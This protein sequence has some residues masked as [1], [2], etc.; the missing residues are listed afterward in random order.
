MK[1]LM[2]LCVFVLLLLPVAASAAATI[3]TSTDCIERAFDLDG[4]TVLYTGEVIGDVMP[5]GEYAWVNVSDGANAIGVW[6]SKDML[7][8]I[9]VAGRYGSVGDSLQITGVFHRACQEHGGDMD[10]HAQQM[11]VMEVGHAASRP[12]SGMMILAA[13]LFAGLDVVLLIVYWR[14]RSPRG[15]R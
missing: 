2:I 11:I 10:I 3:I 12:A 9:S 13:M 14:R 6:I 5:R 7:G 8:M 1:R 15:R 4:Q